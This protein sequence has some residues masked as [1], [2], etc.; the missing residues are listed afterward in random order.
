M[1]FTNDKI[2]NSINTIICPIQLHLEKSIKLDNNIT[3]MFIQK[4][5]N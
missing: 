2:F 1:L 3:Y 5:N 4:K